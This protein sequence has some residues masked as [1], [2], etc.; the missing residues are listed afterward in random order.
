SKEVERVSKEVE[1][2]SKE[3]ERVSKEVE[4]LSKEVRKTSQELRS[5]KESVKGIT[6]G[7]G[8]F[9]EGLVE[10]SFIKF[11]KDKGYRIL[12][13]YRRAIFSKNGKNKEY[14]LIVVCDKNSVFMV[15]AKTFV[16]SESIRDILEDMD[17]FFFFAERYKGNKLYAAIAGMSYGEGADVFAIRSGLY[18][19]K[20]SGEIMEVQTPKNIRVVTS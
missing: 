17:E 13:V 1:R 15:S 14:D 7:W 20:V 3:V 9:V 2:V 5:F 10:P 16:S 8:R 11:L 4:T 18:V 6:D 19:M 12:E